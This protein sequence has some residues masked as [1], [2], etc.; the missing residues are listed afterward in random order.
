MGKYIPPSYFSRS[1]NPFSTRGDPLS[2]EDIASTFIIPEKFFY[3]VQDAF[4]HII[5]GDVG[6]GKTMILRAMSTPVR[7][8]IESFRPDAAN[9]IYN[10]QY[11][12][13]Y[14]SFSAKY[15]SAFCYDEEEI[16]SD[17]KK[18]F[19]I[20]LNTRIAQEWLA[21]ILLFQKTTQSQ[22]LIELE[23][24]FL[25]MVF[26][27]M[28]VSGSV[29]NPNDIGDSLI[30]L[31]DLANTIRNSVDIDGNVRFL[32]NRFSLAKAMDFV[33]SPEDF[34]SSTIEE[35]IRQIPEVLEL[36]PCYLLLDSYEELPEPYQRITNGLFSWRKDQLIYTKVGTLPNGIKTGKTERNR[37]IVRPD[38]AHETKIEWMW[39]SDEY[40]D[41]CRSVATNHLARFAQMQPNIN[42]NRNPENLFLSIKT[43]DEL[44]K[45]TGFS[46]EELKSKTGKNIYDINLE[47][48]DDE[49]RKILFHEI[50]RKGSVKIYNSL[51]ELT[52]LSSGNI[53]TFMRL[54]E[55]S[56]NFEYQQYRKSA[57]NTISIKSQDKAVREVSKEYIT[58]KISTTTLEYQEEVRHLIKTFLRQ[59]QVRHLKGPEEAVWKTLSVVESE[60]SEAFIPHIL[61]ETI[62]FATQ[63][64]FILPRVSADENLLYDFLP[65]FA[66]QFNLNFKTEGI[67]GFNS[68]EF[69]RMFKFYLRRSGSK[70]IIDGKQKNLFG[71]EAP[72]VFVAVPDEPG[73]GTNYAIGVI[74]KVVEKSFNGDLVPVE[75]S[76]EEML[77]EAIRE[78]IR[79]KT[80]I[81]FVDTTRILPNIMFE[82]GI[83]IAS[84]LP[85]YQIYNTAYRKYDNRRQ[86]D[87]LQARR[88]IKYSS[89][90]KKQLLAKE[91]TDRIDRWKNN[92]IKARKCVIRSTCPFPETQTKRIILILGNYT[93]EW[94]DEV[95]PTIKAIGD[96]YKIKVEIAPQ[97]IR[98]GVYKICTRCNLIR[99]SKFTL[100]DV[101][102]K[103]PEMALL[104]GMAFEFDKN[105]IVVKRGEGQWAP[106]C[107]QGKTV[108]RFSSPDELRANLISTIDWG[109]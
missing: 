86:P 55:S 57:F 45:L 109:G 36:M 49:I 50:H 14:I 101:S 8:A 22:R 40:S 64:G 59:L 25:K 73:K 67:L 48:T 54:C 74:R 29:Q 34:A 31:D 26:D 78:V 83:A 44:A 38:E 76:K 97:I 9:R 62:N 107:W 92:I 108:I 27:L 103:E 5:E 100:I 105:P 60:D 32:S 3:R 20:W 28:G 24:R 80:S 51:S 13:I 52:I 91:I 104:L 72:K 96:E 102:S 68:S 89:H 30:I 75:K 81:M 11:T 41:F 82:Y 23:N 17:L 90:S 12:G 33:K 95:F 85:V 15:I 93:E 18:L 42:V 19:R 10:V 58:E 2:D 94:K 106:S 35:T 21:A 77:P 70:K 37:D 53:R 43:V 7:F 6:S 47:T 56:F 87:I 4:H 71:T 16:G 61:Q 79:D 98:N 69:S 46:V 1:A 39:E 65:I 99:E 66:P 88:V 84:K 63:A